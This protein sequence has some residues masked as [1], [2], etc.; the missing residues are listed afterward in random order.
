MIYLLFCFV[1]RGGK[2]GYEFNEIGLDLLGEWVVVNIKFIEFMDSLL[3]S[4]G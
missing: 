1:V 2:I 4:I 3:E